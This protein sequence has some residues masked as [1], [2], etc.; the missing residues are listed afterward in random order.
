MKISKKR[1]LKV[2]YSLIFLGIFLTGTVLALDS[3]GV[4]TV[5]ECKKRADKK[6][7]SF[8]HDTVLRESKSFTKDQAG[9]TFDL[10]NVLVRYDM[11]GF[12]IGRGQTAK[13]ICVLGLRY[14]GTQ[15]KT[16]SW[17]EM[18]RNHDGD[19]LTV[20]S[21]NWQVSYGLRAHNVE[22]GY[23]PIAMTSNKEDY[24]VLENAYMTYIRDD[25]IENDTVMSG[26]IR[27]TLIDGTFMFLS[28]RPS[29]EGNFPQGNSD[30]VIKIVNSLVRLQAMPVRDSV[31]REIGPVCNTDQ[32]T[33]SGAC[34]DGQG[35]G[36]FFKWSENGG[37][38]DISNTILM[39]DE[40]GVAGTR[41]M[42][43][44]PGS[45]YKVILVWLGDGDGDGDFTDDDYPAVLP[46]GVT[47]TRDR[48]VWDERR[49]LWLLRHG[50]PRG[51]DRLQED[52]TKLLNPDPWN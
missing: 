9:F 18:K 48:T 17:D 26:V 47:I 24:W 36:Y 43:F 32:N 35:T 15:S 42:A 41:S 38:V 20:R 6:T 40:I 33:G 28:N 23:F 8:P 27:D 52:C 30:A 39:S 5:N 34:A 2:L 13:N 4:A 3:S 25:A 45:Y 49:S 16:L 46:P 51:G 10:R 19:A 29:P 22:D 12:L 21:S 7:I 37:K 50:C 1:R 14:I 44:P 31:T 11:F